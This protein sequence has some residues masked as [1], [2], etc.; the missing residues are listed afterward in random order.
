MTS[1]LKVLIAYDGSGS[2]N[3]ALDDLRLAGLP[4]KAEAIVLSVAEIT[5]PLPAACGNLGI[6]YTER[7]VA[8]LEPTLAL[9]Q[10]AAEADYSQSCRNIGCRLPLPR[11]AGAGWFPSVSPGQ[12]VLRCRCARPV[13]GRNRAGRRGILNNWLYETLGTVKRE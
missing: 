13:L 8:R 10:R 9:A 4:G 12:R 11:H 2:A 6:D 3:T 7:P 1:N 5:L